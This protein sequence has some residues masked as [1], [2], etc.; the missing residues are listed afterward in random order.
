MKKL[1]LGFAALTML[2]TACKENTKNAE[3]EMNDG[4]ME[5]QT[6]TTESEDMENG[7]TVADIAMGDDQFSTLV[8]GVQAAGLGETLQSDG[9]FTVFAPTNQAFSKLPEGTLND[10]LKPENKEKLTGI[11]TY[12]VVPGEYAAADII[13]AIKDN[14][15]AYEITTVE[16]GKLTASLDGDKVI[17]TDENSGEATVEQA[18]VKGSN[19]IIHGINTVLMPKN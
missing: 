9:P 3:D 1:I 8:Q 15:G 7:E 19:G 10:L 16:G 6:M 13:K 11:L 4:A 5:E 2:F 17:V 18:D 14:T 12:H